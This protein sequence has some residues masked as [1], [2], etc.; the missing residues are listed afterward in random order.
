MGLSGCE[1]PGP[2]RLSPAGARYGD[3]AGFSLLEVMVA[4]TLM[5]LVMVV[6]L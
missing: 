1:G 3:A 6:L 5:G 2:E 4:T